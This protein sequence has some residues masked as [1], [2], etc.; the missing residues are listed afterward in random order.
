[1]ILVKLAEN[2]FQRTLENNQ[3]GRSRRGD[4]VVSGSSS[5]RLEN[6]LNCDAVVCPELRPE[7]RPTVPKSVLNRVRANFD[8]VRAHSAGVVIWNRLKKPRFE[9]K[10]ARVRPPVPT[11]LPVL[12]QNSALL[13]YLTGHK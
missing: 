11:P 7:L 1:M 8:G 2:N 5:I 13:A 9:H 10:N 12:R 6:P 3:L 4:F